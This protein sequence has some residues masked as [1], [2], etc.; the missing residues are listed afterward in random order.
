VHSGASGPRCMDALFF[1]LEWDRYRFHKKRAGTR[2][3]ELVFLHLVSSAGHVVH[4][5]CVWDVRHHRTILH[6]RV[7]LVWFL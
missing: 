7:G 6:A 2:Y 4:S 5:G 3:V 1:I